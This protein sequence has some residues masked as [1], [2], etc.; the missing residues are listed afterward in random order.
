[1][2]DKHPICYVT[3]QTPFWCSF[4]FLFITVSFRLCDLLW[5]WIHSYILKMSSYFHLSLG[6]QSRC[7]MR[8]YCGNKRCLFCAYRGWDFELRV[9]NFEISIVIDDNWAKTFVGSFF[10]WFW[11]LG[12]IVGNYFHSALGDHFWWNHWVS[13]I[14][15]GSVVCKGSTSPVILSLLLFRYFSNWEF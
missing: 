2:Q 1:M 15:P 13:R 8:P 4:E 14:K 12:V 6:W 9:M 3:F 11:Y 7:R 10:V 5:L